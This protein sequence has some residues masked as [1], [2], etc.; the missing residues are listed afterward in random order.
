MVELRLPWTAGISLMR[1]LPQA[2]TRQSSCAC[3]SSLATCCTSARKARGKGRHKLQVH[4]L[5]RPI[6]ALLNILLD[7]LLNAFA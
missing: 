2:Q 5:S 7:V 4:A 3:L 1:K 6:D